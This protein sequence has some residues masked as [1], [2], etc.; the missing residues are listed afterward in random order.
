MAYGDG[1]FDIINGKYRYRKS[2]VS[3]TN[4]KSY[5]LTVSGA[6]QKECREKMQRR[7]REKEAAIKAGFVHSLDNSNVSLYSG[8]IDWLKNER[9]GVVKQTTYDRL[10]R[11]IENQIGKR[12]ALGMKQIRSI[13]S[14]DL[15]T[16]LRELQEKGLA[17]STVDKAYEV[18]NQFFRFYYAN[19]I[20][21]NPMNIVDKPKKLKGLV[22][23]SVDDEVD[24][25]LEDVVLSDDE[26]KR[27]KK[28]AFVEYVSG[29]KHTTRHGVALYFIMMTVLRF[30]EAIAVTWKD[31]D[32]DKRVMIISKNQTTVKN[33]DENAKKKTKRIITTPKNDKTREV[34]L[35][36]EAVEALQWI[37]QRSKYT[38]P[39][40]FVICGSTGKSPSNHNLSKTLDSVMTEAGLNTPARDKKF[41]L[42]YLRHT[43]ISYYLRHGI[44]MELVSK[45]AGHSSVAI[46]ER[47]YYHI[48]HDQQKKMLEL[49]DGI[50]I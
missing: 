33:R 17:Q 35:N 4:G 6:S 26:I 29:S 11:T 47:V 41:G 31:I 48:I 38:A 22:E 5:R 37:K 28:A 34:M 7:E 27:F 9:Y 39:T 24:A 10:E 19:N 13:T 49:M 1:T 36:A 25:A 8:M 3:K 15:K 12:S 40:D 43:G 42:H 50:E 45:M 23:V 32:F 20:Y 14:R 46:T 16:Y 30:G 18:L 44:P 21:D 2:F